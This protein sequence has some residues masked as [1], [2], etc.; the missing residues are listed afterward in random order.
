M[1]ELKKKIFRKITLENVVKLE[2]K[3]QLT[4]FETDSRGYVRI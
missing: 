1:V 4:C 2:D 3:T